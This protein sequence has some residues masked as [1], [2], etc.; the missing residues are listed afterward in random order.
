MDLNAIKSKLESLQS[1]TTTS[2]NFW[3]P[4]P[5]KQVV[6]IVARYDVTSIFVNYNGNTYNLSELMDIETVPQTENEEFTEWMLKQHQK[7]EQEANSTY[8]CD[9][10]ANPHFLRFLGAM[11]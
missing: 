5:G 10:S 2:N 1:Q 3:K 7:M 9:P 11:C 6:R 4:E 8:L